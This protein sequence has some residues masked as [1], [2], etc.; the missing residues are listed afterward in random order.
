MS[1]KG[2][3]KFKEKL[4]CGLE[5]DLRN[6]VNFYASSW[7]S[8]N[9]QYVGLLL[10]NAY[11]DLDEKV[12]K[13]YVS[14]PWKVMQN[15]R[16]KWLFVPKITWEIWLILNASSTKSENLHFDLLVLL[17]AHKVSAK[18]VQKNDLSWHLR[19]I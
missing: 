19:K 13:S 9:L 1:L 17:I 5:N 2:Y 8:G 6:L 15:L 16:S 11:K 10:S 4:T 18:K 3:P 12:P 14:W 7:K